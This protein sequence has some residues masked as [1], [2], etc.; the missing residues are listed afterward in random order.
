MRINNAIKSINIEDMPY[1][2]AFQDIIN[3]AE[4]AQSRY[5]VLTGSA[6]NGKTN[7]L[8]S[9]TELLIHLKQGVVFSAALD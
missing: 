6:G 1:E 8:C 9:I 5:Y 4:A 2:V 7:M 3:L